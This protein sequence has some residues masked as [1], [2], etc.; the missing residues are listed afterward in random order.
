MTFKA[1]LRLALSPPAE[2]SKRDT[3]LR[4]TDIL[5]GFVIREIFLRLQQWSELDGIV[6]AQL[7]VCSVL[8][9]GSWI[10]FRRSL[11]RSAYEVK[12]V[13]LPLVRF[14]L[15]QAMVVLYFRITSLSG[16]LDGLAT[17]QPPADLA[18]QTAWNLVLVFGLYVL[19]DIFGILMARATDRTKAGAGMPPKYPRIG[20]DDTATTD[21]QV[22][23]WGGFAI[24]VVA[25]AALVVAWAATDPAPSRGSSITV[26]VLAAVLLFLYRL[27][28]EVRT[29]WQSG[30]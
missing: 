3:S 16:P 20:S 11:N 8:V 17:A 15:D 10:G 2:V 27:A 28:K 5:F 18:Q 19:W 12:F 7:V 14:V 24:T 22:V 26:L 21:R 30:A 4:F 29:S 13:N 25:F 23:N 1:R 6:Q 9:L